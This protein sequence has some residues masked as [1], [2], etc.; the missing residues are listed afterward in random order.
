VHVAEEVCGAATSTL[1]KWEVRASLA[2]GEARNRA[3]VICAKEHA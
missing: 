3:L 1:A 2:P